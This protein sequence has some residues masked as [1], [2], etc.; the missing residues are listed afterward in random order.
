MLNSLKSKLKNLTEDHEKVFLV[1]IEEKDINYTLESE[2]WFDNLS[3]KVSKKLKKEKELKR[4]NK[5]AFER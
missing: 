1:T 3:F 2:E 4:P 5:E